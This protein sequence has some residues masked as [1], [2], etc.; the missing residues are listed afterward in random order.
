MN[1]TS[2]SSQ[3]LDRINDLEEQ[4]HTAEASRNAKAHEETITRHHTP[5]WSNTLYPKV[6]HMF[7]SKTYCLGSPVSYV[8]FFTVGY[9]IMTIS[10]YC[11]RIDSPRPNGS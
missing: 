7:H 4:L 3:G 11:H 1:E 2:D 6:F 10:I 5:D 9:S 8:S